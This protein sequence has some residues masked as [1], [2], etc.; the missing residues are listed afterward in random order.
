MRLYEDELQ[1]LEDVMRLSEGMTYKS[2]IAGLDLGGGKA[3]IVADPGMKE[4]REELFA[5]FGECLNHLAGRYVTAEDMGTSVSDIMTIRKT[6]SYV[7]GTDPAE[8]GGGDPSPWT[9]LGV[10]KSIE[11]VATSRLKRDNLAGLR[12]AIQGVGHVGLYLLKR[13]H[14]AGAKCTVCDVSA[15]ALETAK[16]EFGAE[17]VETE[18]IYD[19]DCDI[20]APCAIGQTINPETIPRLRCSVISGAANNQLLDESVY[21]MLDDRQ[22]VYC[23]DF[24]VNSGGV[25]CVGAEYLNEGYDECRVKEKVENIYHTTLRVLDEAERRGKFTE[26]VAVELAKE[27]V[28]AAEESAST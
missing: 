10:F 11:A 13:L 18:A 26:V 12:V 27:R 15:T 28:A 9:A 25:I 19:A 16:N 4:G 7:T 1:A 8:G 3:C 21:A 5:K 24:V 6:S 20:F 17:V 22:I 2:S 23:P 14:D